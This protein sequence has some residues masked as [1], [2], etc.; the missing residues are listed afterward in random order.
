VR[1]IGSA[2]NGTGDGFLSGAF[3]DLPPSGDPLTAL[4][5]DAAQGEILNFW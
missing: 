5:V 1:S 3:Q 4:T 2:K